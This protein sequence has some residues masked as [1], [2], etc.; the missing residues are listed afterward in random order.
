LID[1]KTTMTSL[2]FPFTETQVRALKV[3]DEVSV[4]GIVFAKRGRE[5]LEVVAVNTEDSFESPGR[6]DA[7]V[8]PE[9]LG[10]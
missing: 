3:G 5:E 9:R 4:S 10:Q 6:M 2:T 1:F 7:E 8:A